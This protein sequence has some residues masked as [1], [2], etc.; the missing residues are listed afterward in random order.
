M[1]LNCKKFLFCF[2][3]LIGVYSV[4][5]CWENEKKTNM[6]YVEIDLTDI[7]DANC[8]KLKKFLENNNTN[9]NSIDESEILLDKK[10]VKEDNKYKTEGNIVNSIKKVFLKNNIVKDI[11]YI[12][13][14]DI[15]ECCN[16]LPKDLFIYFD[17]SKDVILSKDSSEL[18]KYYDEKK[19]S[20]DIKSIKSLQVG[21]LLRKE[22]IDKNTNI[23]N[24]LNFNTSDKNTDILY[25]IFKKKS[26][27]DDFIDDIKFDL[28][29]FYNDKSEK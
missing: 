2:F 17:G 22:L 4:N 10:N 14:K 5:A 16:N 28:E 7:S 29:I 27:K 9:V 19:R 25:L 15:D 20:G 8:E 3:N 12:C 23:N 24:S 26:E 21:T 18:K 6:K 1:I 13:L 11:K